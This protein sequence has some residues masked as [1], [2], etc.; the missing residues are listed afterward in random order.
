[1]SSLVIYSSGVIIFSTLSVF[2][3]DTKSMIA[4]YMIPKIVN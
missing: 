1:M 3:P 4:I 2:I